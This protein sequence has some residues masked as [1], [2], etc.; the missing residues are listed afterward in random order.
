MCRF[1]GAFL[2][3]SPP[4]KD[5]DFGVEKDHPDSYSIGLVYPPIFRTTTLDFESILGQLQLSH[6]SLVDLNHGSENLTF[7]QQEIQKSVGPNFTSR[8][9]T[10]REFVCFMRFN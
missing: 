1:F 10:S 3:S 4:Q 5:M 6:S 2:T 9:G 7:S 8:G